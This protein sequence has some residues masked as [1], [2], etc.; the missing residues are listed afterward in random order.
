VLQVGGPA[1]ALNVELNEKDCDGSTP[2]K[3]NEKAGEGAIVGANAGPLVGSS[4]GESVGA[5]VGSLVGKEVGVLEGA[6]DDH[7]KVIW[8]GLTIFF[9]V[10]SESW[11]EASWSASL[12]STPKSTTNIKTDL[13]SIL[14]NMSSNYNTL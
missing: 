9:S 13:K 1:T 12:D 10:E 3:R 11:I 14:I 7:F 8:E 2:L 5:K 6:K 4:D